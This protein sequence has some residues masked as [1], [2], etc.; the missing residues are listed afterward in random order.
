MHFKCGQTV[1]FPH[2]STTTGHKIQENIW[3][4]LCSLEEGLN[5]RREAENENVTSTKLVCLASRTVTTAWTSS[6]SFCFSS[7]SNCIYHLASLVF[8]ARFWIRMK[9]IYKSKRKTNTQCGWI[10]KGQGVLFSNSV[11]HHRRPDHG[12]ILMYTELGEFLLHR[13]GSVSLQ[14]S[15]RI[16]HLFNK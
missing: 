4:S 9:R 13:S 7:S 16:L 1:T 15:I 10:K 2:Q 6:M 14:M 8:P 5:L 12:C 3:I 11:A